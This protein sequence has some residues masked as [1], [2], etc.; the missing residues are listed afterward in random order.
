MWV[1]IF[2]QREILM[3][4]MC[5]IWKLLQ[6]VTGDLPPSRVCR[7]PLCRKDSFP[8]PRYVRDPQHSTL[9]DWLLGVSFWSLWGHPAAGGHWWSLPCRFVLLCSATAL[10]IHLAAF[11]QKSRGQNPPSSW[12]VVGHYLQQSNI[13]CRFFCLVIF[14]LDHFTNLFY[15]LAAQREVPGQPWSRAG[16]AGCPPGSR[17]RAAGGLLPSDHGTWLELSW[18]T[19]TSPN[20]VLKMS[21]LQH[22]PFCSTGLVPCHSL[23][24]VGVANSKFWLLLLRKRMKMLKNCSLF[25]ASA[26]PLSWSIQLVL[27]WCYCRIGILLVTARYP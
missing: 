15:N 11:L 23:V 14:N 22:H 10:K 8:D 7:V 6:N 17:G 1:I 20:H 26:V 16:R 13:L 25:E 5:S 24:I 19:F 2:F 12:Q 9:Q 4:F 3:D 27:L 18:S 21:D